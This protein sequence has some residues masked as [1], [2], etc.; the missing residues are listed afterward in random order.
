[1]KKNDYPIEEL[2]QQLNGLIDSEAD[3]D[4]I[5]ALSTKLDKLIMIYYEDHPEIA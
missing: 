5:Y 3:Y 1:M 4:D 2:R